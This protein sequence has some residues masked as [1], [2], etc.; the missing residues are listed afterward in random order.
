MNR[1][2]VGCALLTIAVMSAAVYSAP[3]KMM[4]GFAEAGT[5]IRPTIQVQ[6]EPGEKLGSAVVGDLTGSL[7]YALVL[8]TLLPGKRGRIRVLHWQ[9]DHYETVGTFTDEAGSIDSLIIEDITG[10]RRGDLI[11]LWR[12]G[13][14][15]Y[16]NVLIFEWTGQNYRKIWDLAPFE[17]GGQ[18][19]ERALLAIRRIDQIGNVELVIRAP[20][21]RPGERTP[22]PLPHQVSIYR[23]DARKQTLVLFKRFVDPSRTFE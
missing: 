2:V 8:G 10:H 12:S 22:G 20:N 4:R 17:K 21:V 16:L 23:W 6:L 19:T 14:G 3:Q 9:K 13:Q 5:P 7:E 18:L 15:G 11:T 1:R